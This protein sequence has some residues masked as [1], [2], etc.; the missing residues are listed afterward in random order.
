MTKEILDDAEII[1]DLCNMIV[2]LCNNKNL[3]KRVVIEDLKDMLNYRDNPSI[4]EIAM[5]REKFITD[6]D[7]SH[8]DKTCLLSLPS[9][10]FMTKT[11]EE[12]IKISKEKNY[13]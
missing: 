3:P 11:P 1:H 13:K 8:F 9:E 5:W 4:E 12:W 6:K 2:K 7:L 10:K